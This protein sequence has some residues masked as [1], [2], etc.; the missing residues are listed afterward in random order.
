[1]YFQNKPRWERRVV[2][3]PRL[4]KHRGFTLIELIIAMVLLSVVLTLLYTSFFQIS[5]NVRKLSGQLSEQQEMRMLMKMISD[6]LQAAQYFTNF[7]E[8][9]EGKSGIK[10]VMD[11]IDKNEFTNIQFHSATFTRFYRKV[12]R[13]ADPHMHE[14]AYWVELGEDRKTLKFIRRE[15]FFLDDDMEEGGV[16]VVLAEGLESFK[17]EFLPPGSAGKVQERWETDWDSSQGTSLERM[18]VALRITL[19]KKTEHGQEIKQTQEFNLVTSMV[20]K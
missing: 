9:N 4:R 6:D 5:T 16:K 20:V 7:A 13:E 1:M 12:P 17:V 19:A 2:S 10:A 15:D 8:Q 11:R 18:P 14:I 3:N